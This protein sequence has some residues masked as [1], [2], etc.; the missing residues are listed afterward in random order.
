MRVPAVEVFRALP[1][2]EGYAIEPGHVLAVRLGQ[3]CVAIQA[4]CQGHMRFLKS[5]KLLVNELAAAGNNAPDSPLY[6]S[7]MDRAEPNAL[8]GGLRAALAF[9]RRDGR[10]KIRPRAFPLSPT[11]Q[12]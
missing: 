11:R 8:A 2:I 1:A 3:F 10:S 12:P 5:E 6:L 4:N 9:L 7:G